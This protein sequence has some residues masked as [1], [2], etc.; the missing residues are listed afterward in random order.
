MAE[1]GHTSVRLFWE[2]FDVSSRCDK[3]V[4]SDRQEF[5]P[6]MLGTARCGGSGGQRF[7]GCRDA[8]ASTIRFT[9]SSTRMFAVKEI[10]L[11]LI[12]IR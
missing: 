11:S 2:V 3:R 10:H 8:G 1:K 9:A 4:R 7:G 6:R 12:R 5:L